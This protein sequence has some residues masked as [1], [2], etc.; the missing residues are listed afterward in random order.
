MT[1]R[2]SHKACQLLLIQQIIRGIINSSLSIQIYIE[3]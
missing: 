2:V 1:N 3:I